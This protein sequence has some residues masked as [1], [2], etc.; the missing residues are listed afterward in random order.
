MNLKPSLFALVIL[1]FFSCKIFNKRQIDFTKDDYENIESI[2]KSYFISNFK[3]PVDVY[4]IIEFDKYTR[5]FNPTTKKILKNGIQHYIVKDSSGYFVMSYKNKN[6]VSLGKTDL[7]SNLSKNRLY[8]TMLYEIL[9]YKNGKKNISYKNYKKI[10]D[11]LNRELSKVLSKHNT[12]SIVKYEYIKI[13]SDSI[14]FKCSEKAYNDDYINDVK[15]IFNEFI[16]ET[17]SDSIKL[18]IPVVD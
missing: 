13:Y 5:H 12:N 16:N 9:T 18:I 1:L 3:Y 17:K 11:S 8:P 14:Y 10:K 15:N 6:I 7:C 2:I 4:E